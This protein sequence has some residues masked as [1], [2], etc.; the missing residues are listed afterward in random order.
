VSTLSSGL[1]QAFQKLAVHEH[2]Q[3]YRRLFSFISNSYH[4][5]ADKMGASRI[6]SGPKFY[7]VRTGAKPGIYHTYDDCLAQVKGFK[8]AVCECCSAAGLGRPSLTMYIVKSFPTLSEAEAFVKGEGGPSAARGGQKFY[9][10]HR[11]VRP[12]VYTTWDEA[13]KQ[14]TNTK[15]PVF[16]S[17]QT[18][19]DAEAFVKTGPAEKDKK[20]GSRSSVITGAADEIVIPASVAKR[21]ISEVEGS[22]SKTKT[23]A[24]KKQKKATTT[25]IP[26]DEEEELD[27]SVHTP[28]TGPLP[29][30]AEDGFDPRIILTPCQD[31]VGTIRG[32]I[33][34][35]DYSQRD[36][37]KMQP[38]GIGMDTCVDIYTDGSCKNNGK[39]GKASAGWGVYFGPYDD[40]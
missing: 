10:V 39:Q 17:F 6:R 36:T 20:N 15:M 24:A 26:V 37:W 9:A 14:V 4:D 8:K 22:A 32:A 40:R 25:E 1:R 11:G 13:K 23:P 27:E 18:Q 31:G 29:P 38:I 30:G 2:P 5:P 19:E 3:S 33:E 28:G 35:K 7:A 21:R 12:G 34:Y 16:K